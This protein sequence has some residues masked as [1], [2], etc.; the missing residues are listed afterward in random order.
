MFCL[1]SYDSIKTNKSQRM[2]KQ[3]FYL[4]NVDEN[5][6]N[7]KLVMTYVNRLIID[8]DAECE[9]I[10]SYQ[11]KKS[12]ELEFSEYTLIQK[13]QYLYSLILQNEFKNINILVE[14]LENIERLRLRKDNEFQKHCIIGMPLESSLEFSFFLY[15]ISI[16]YSTHCSMLWSHSENL[17]TNN[18]LGD[19]DITI[20]DDIDS[21]IDTFDNFEPIYGIWNPIKAQRIISIK[22]V[23]F[24][25]LIAFDKKY[26]AL[27]ESDDLFMKMNCQR[28]FIPEQVYPE[29]SVI[30]IIFFTLVTEVL[31]ILA[32]VL[33]RKI[34]KR[35]LD[36]LLEKTNLSLVTKFCFVCLR[37]LSLM[38]VIWKSRIKLIAF[39]RFGNSFVEAMIRVGLSESN[40]PNTYPKVTNCILYFY[41]LIWICFDLFLVDSDIIFIRNCWNNI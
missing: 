20:G 22:P 39:M 10:E 33:Y 5:H 1:I 29:R 25:D 31:V 24:E 13:L 4:L 15:F 41:Y 17:T 38:V 27:K 16:K 23:N 35:G 26:S 40:L 14:T 30:F 34:T 21:L 2:K 37:Q 8:E 36:F 32:P 11:L 28:R 12:T 7:F 19:S 6:I 3:L 18:N 9:V